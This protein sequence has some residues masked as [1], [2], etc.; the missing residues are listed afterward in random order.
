MCEEFISLIGARMLDQIISEIKKCKYYSISLDS[1][2][3]SANVDQLTFIVRYVLPSGPVEE[4]IKFLDME[5]HSS[6]KL[7][8]IL[9]DFLNERGIN[10]TDCRGQ[11]YNNASNMSGKYNGLHTLIKEKSQF[12][13]S[14][15]CF[16]HSLN[17]VGKF[18]A[19]CC[20]EVARF[21]IFV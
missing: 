18:A 2:P 3:D 6:A 21:F 15:P 14:I 16:A 19:E 1:T 8:D 17:L 13:E 12:A 20:P 5:E 9:M 7:T 11:S 10:I 4:F